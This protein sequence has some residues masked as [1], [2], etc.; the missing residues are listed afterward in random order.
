[1]S[2]SLGN[3][4]HKKFTVEALKIVKNS[5]DLVA[6]DQGRGRCPIS[7]AIPVNVSYFSMF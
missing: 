7:I 6:L 2:K 4:L 1:M 3:D 5:T